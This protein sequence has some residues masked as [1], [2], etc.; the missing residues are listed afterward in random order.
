MLVVG[1][2]HRQAEEA[3]GLHHRQ[4]RRHALR[5]L[6]DRDGRAQGIPQRAQPL[7]QLV[8]ALLLE[9]SLILSHFCF[10][11]ANVSSSVEFIVSFLLEL[12]I[13]PSVSMKQFLILQVCRHHA[14]PVALEASGCKEI[15]ACP[16]HGWEYGASQLTLFSRHTIY[17]FLNDCFTLHCIQ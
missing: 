17:N 13:K 7:F 14:S 5:H 15:F 8:S 12:S 4:H 11:Q 6:H 1:G 10:S 16:Y 9:R 3:R 2:P